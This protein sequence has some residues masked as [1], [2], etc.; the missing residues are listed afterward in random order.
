MACLLKLIGQCQ[1][2]RVPQ[3][4]VSVSRVYDTS[5]DHGHSSKRM[6]CDEAVCR[7]DQSSNK[8]IPPILKSSLSEVQCEN[9]REQDVERVDDSMTTSP[10]DARK[11]IIYIR[12]WRGKLK[13]MATDIFSQPREIAEFRGRKHG[14][15]LWVPQQQRLY[16]IGGFMYTTSREVK[17]LERSSL[18]WTT[19]AEMIHERAYFSS[20]IVGN[21]IF[22][23]SCSRVYFFSSVQMSN[24]A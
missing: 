15:L 22:A 8:G 3:Q 23:V 14:E 10:T 21:Y 24:F 4:G 20:V 2:T 17:Y 1:G 12:R 18:Q 11:Q 6:R 5:V 16:I 9:S 19:V 7:I 13:L